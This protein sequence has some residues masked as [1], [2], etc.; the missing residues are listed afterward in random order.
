MPSATSIGFKTVDYFTISFIY[1]Y[2]IKS[3]GPSR[4]PYGTI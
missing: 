1:I 4:D 2:D 3:S